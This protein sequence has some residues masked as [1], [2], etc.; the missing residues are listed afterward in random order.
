M[1]FGLMGTN[2]THIYVIILTITLI[3]RACQL[4]IFSLSLAVWLFMGFKKGRK[5]KF[6]DKSRSLVGNF[7]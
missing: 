5:G 1:K 6:G 2:T 3:T 4:N 7:G